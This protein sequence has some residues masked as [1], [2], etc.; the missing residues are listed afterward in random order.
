MSAVLNSNYQWSDGTTSNKTISCSIRKATPTITLSPT[1]GS[2]NVGQN[3]TF[4]EKATVAGMF[5]NSSNST[6]IA[7]VSPSGVS[8]SANTNKTVTITGK[9]AG[10]ATIT[11]GFTPT[12]T[13][14]YNIAS[15]TY[16]VSV[17]QTKTCSWESQ[18]S[19][20]SSSCSNTSKPANPN[21][22]DTY[23]SCGST[24]YYWRKTINC[25]DGSTKTR[26]GSTYYSSETAARTACNNETTNGICSTGFTASGWSCTILR[27]KNTYKYVCK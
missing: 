20:L 15:K 1:S 17:I 13:T 8:A 18:S 24:Q 9:G 3:I 7:I 6:S 23:I 2:V 25:S 27:Y 26:S 4:T 22:G 19:V 21:E 11:V 14:N 10:S 16:S 5:S 12:D